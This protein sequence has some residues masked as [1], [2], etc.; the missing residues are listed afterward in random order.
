MPW[1]KVILL[2]LLQVCLFVGTVAGVMLAPV[3]GGPTLA[4]ACG[5]LVM[6]LVN[7]YFVRVIK[8]SKGWPAHPDR[9]G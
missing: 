9:L 3:P 6:F 1:F 4:A 2:I 8:R 5:I 7:S